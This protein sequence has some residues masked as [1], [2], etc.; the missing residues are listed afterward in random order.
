MSPLLVP[1]PHPGERRVHRHAS[2]AKPPKPQRKDGSPGPD[3]WRAP[4]GQALRDGG[5]P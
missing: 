2:E 3:R 5:A 4:G 1:I